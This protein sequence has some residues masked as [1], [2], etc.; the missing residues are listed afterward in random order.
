MQIMAAAGAGVV[1]RYGWRVD[2]EG[3]DYDLH[4][5]V[6]GDRCTVDLRLTPESLHR[7]GRFVHVPASLNPTLGHA[8][9][10]LSEPQPGEVFLDPT[11]GAGTV[12]L[13]RAALGPARLIAGDLFARPVEVAR[14]NV[15]AND[16]TA[17]VLRW[18]ARRLPLAAESVDK[19]CANLPWGRRAGSHLV[20]KHLYPALVREIA[21]V[22]R[23]GGLAV[24]LTLERRM[25]TAILDRHGWLRTVEVL[26]VVVGGL[27]PCIY[28]V[29]KWRG[30]E[31]PGPGN[32]G[33]GT[34]D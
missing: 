6:D 4:V 13:E 20:N 26:P 9:C 32:R 33:P 5:N 1:D 17:Q 27:R 24:L 2:L 11:C 10:V 12:L 31:R 34:V 28:V 15:E 8:L 14:T 16:I 29:R 21:R 18:D 19:V 3:Y 30:Q 23:V 25:L 7:R 22:L